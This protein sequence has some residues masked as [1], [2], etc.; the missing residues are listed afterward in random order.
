M[1]RTL[2]VKGAN[3]NIAARV[4][5]APTP[6]QVSRRKNLFATATYL[7]S[8]GALGPFEEVQR[9]IGPNL[10]LANSDDDELTEEMSEADENHENK[11]QKLA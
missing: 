9:T 11:K 1:L 10:V 7:Y 5:E 3:F 2:F 4:D 8:N 6:L